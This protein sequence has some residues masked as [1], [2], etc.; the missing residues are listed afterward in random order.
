MAQL[1]GFKKRDKVFKFEVGD[2]IKDN[3]SGGWMGYM[4]QTKESKAQMP[5]RDWLRATSEEIPYKIKG[6]LRKDPHRFENL[7]LIEEKEVT[8]HTGDQSWIS[9]VW[10][11]ISV[12]ENDP[13]F[14][15][16]KPVTDEEGEVKQLFGVLVTATSFRVKGQDIAKETSKQ[17]MLRKDI[18]YKTKYLKE[19]INKVRPIHDMVFRYNPLDPRAEAVCDIDHLDEMIDRCFNAVKLASESAIKKAQENLDKITKLREE[20]GY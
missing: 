16:P 10:K 5:Y 4:P 15:A 17:I 9:Y 14:D 11:V 3:G 20:N 2:L 6:A 13:L 8:N 7:E 18:F 12:N 19:E 1:N